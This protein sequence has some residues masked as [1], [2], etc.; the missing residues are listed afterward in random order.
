MPDALIRDGDVT[1]PDRLYLQLDGFDGPLDLLLDLARAQKVELH[2]I[3]V[4][5]L[6]DQYL[7]IVEGARRVRLEL[8]A[9]WLVMAAWLAWLKSRLLLPDDPAAAEDAEAGAGN[10]ADRLRELQAVRAAAAALGER[11]QLGRDVWSRGVPES[12]EVIDRS[13]YRLSTGAL[14]AAYMAAMRRAGGLRSYTPPAPVLWSVN[15]ALAR[16]SALLGRMPDWSVLERF[17]PDLPVGQSGPLHRRAAVASTLIASLEMARAG[18]LRLRQDD[19]F[20]PILVRGG[21]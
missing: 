14:V 17:V 18:A 20:G 4:L 16:L 10:L 1:D 3:S 8:Q 13:G 21:G 19:P 2:R 6:V 11:R 15:D 9:D 12:F 5:D 7:R